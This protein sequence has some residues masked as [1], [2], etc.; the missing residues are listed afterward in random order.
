[1]RRSLLFLVL[2]LFS[3]MVQ[4]EDTILKLYRPFGDDTENNKRIITRTLQGDCLSQSKYIVREDAWRCHAQGVVFDPCFVKAAPRQKNLLCPQ[5][6]WSNENVQIEV[7]SALNNEGHELLDMSR[8][9]PWAI[10]LIDGDKCQAIEAG[11]VY[12]SLP[13]RYRCASKNI[14]IGRIQRCDPAW[15]MLE[16]TSQQVVTAQ[17]KRA[18]F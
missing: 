17:L 14:L 11:E 13:V 6:P 7:S 16:K 8:T 18:W 4:A 5:S 1:M 2:L 3:F 10:E 15:S 12:D 9:F